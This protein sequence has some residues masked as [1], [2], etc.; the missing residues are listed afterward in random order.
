MKINGL[1]SLG[2]LLAASLALTLGGCGTTPPSPG[3]ATDAVIAGDP[4][5]SSYSNKWRIELSEAARSDGEIVFQITPRSGDSQLVTVAIESSFGENHV[6]RAIRDAFRDQL[7]R[8]QYS[9][10]RDD[11]EDVLVKKHHG[12]ADFSLR[13]ISSTV[14]AVRVRVQKE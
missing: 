10:E 11:G 14:S 3:S 5:D 1:L 9:I 7:D 6:A 8:D 4:A 2:L 12:E 13:V